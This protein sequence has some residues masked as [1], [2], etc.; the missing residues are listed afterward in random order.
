MV[1]FLSGSLLYSTALKIF[2]N[3]KANTGVN[4]RVPYD[5]WTKLDTVSALLTIIG[6]PFIVNLVPEHFVVRSSKDL[7][8]MLMLAII[9]L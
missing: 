2:F 6:F 1:F 7:V 9:T 4:N 5:R 8:D 3:V